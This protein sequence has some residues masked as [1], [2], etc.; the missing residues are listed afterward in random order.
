MPGT[1]PRGLCDAC[2]WARLVRS[3]RGSGF[4]RCGR[5]D[6]EPDYP[7]YPALPVRSCPGF[8]A[9]DLGGGAAAPSPDPLDPCAGRERDVGQTPP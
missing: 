8:A 3:Q 4:L 1:T 9:A 7:R 2:L 6:T 5:S